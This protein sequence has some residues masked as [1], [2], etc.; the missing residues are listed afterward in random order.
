MLARKGIDPSELL[1]RHLEGD[2]GVISPEDWIANR[3]ALRRKERIFSAYM[4][5]DQKIWIITEADRSS[6]CILLPSEY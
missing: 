1:D 6:T 2:F 4:V 3:R 5:D